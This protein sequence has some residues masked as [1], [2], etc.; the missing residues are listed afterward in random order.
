[1]PV[2]V[3]CGVEN[4]DQARFCMA[5]AAPLATDG[6]DRRERRVV[7]VLFADIVGYTERSER[8]D[9]EDVEDLL[10]GYYAMLRRDLER[11]GG[12]VEKFIGDA[13]V[14]VFG[15]PTAHEDDPERAVRAGFAIQESVRELRA[16]A[17]VEIQVRVGITT[18]EALVTFGASDGGASVV[19]D[20]MNT[21]ARIQSAAPTGSVLV[22]EVTRDASHRVIRY[23]PADAIEAKGKSDPVTVWLAV[24]PR[25]TVPEQPRVTDVPLVGRGE[26]IAQLLAVLGR[27]RREPSTQLVTIVGP[28]GIGKSRLLRELGRRVEPG[29]FR[30][31][32]GRS[33]A[34]G[35]G[36]TFWALGEMVKSEAQILEF[37]AADVAASKLERAIAAVVE[38]ERDRAWIGQHLRPLVGLEGMA[39]PSSE[40]RGAEAFAAWRRFFEALAERQPTILVF[41]D[42]HWADDA[43]LDFVDLLTDR[44]GDVPLL[45]VCTARPELLERRSGWGGGKTNSTRSLRSSADSSTMPR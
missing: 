38:D 41:E 26:E 32:R 34:Y 6:G 39:S 44:A 25:S 7:S 42:V 13:V 19:G 33:L 3:V 15:A 30:W 10:R 27:S 11:H 16:R 5:C 18:G 31:L 36:I 43:L 37:D 1:M 9:V 4:P 45:I 22:D 17:A 14:A 21:A 23:T 29:L 2:C 8:S 12:V 35:D 28:P 24:E 20:V 40:G